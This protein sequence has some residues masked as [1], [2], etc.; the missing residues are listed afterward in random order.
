MSALP[1]AARPQADL[2]QHAQLI[3]HAIANVPPLTKKAVDP[4]SILRKLRMTENARNAA[5]SHIKTIG[6]DSMRFTNSIED[7]VHAFQVFTDLALHL[8]PEIERDARSKLVIITSNSVP[9]KSKDKQINFTRTRTIFQCQCGIDNHDGRHASKTREMGWEDVGCGAWMRVT[10]THDKRDSDKS[11]HV[12]LT[13]DEIIGDFSHS[14]LCPDTIKMSRDPRIPLHPD[15]RDYALSL[16]R[17]NIPLPQLRQHCR[18]WAHKHWGMNVGDK[19]YRYVFCDHETT[20]LYRTLAREAG[21]PQRSAAQDNLHLW[22]NSEDPHPPDPRLSA[23]RV[24]YSPFIP[25]QTERFSII[26]MTPEQKLLAWKFGHRKQLLMD[27]T[28]GV[29]NGRALLGILMALDDEMKGL[30][31]A[32]FLFTAKQ[33]TKAVHAD[34]NKALLEEQ[35]QLWK[36]G[37]GKND[38]G[39]EFEAYVAGTDNDPRERHALRAAWSQ[40]LLLLCIFHIWQ[41]WRNALNKFLRIIPEVSDRQQTRQHL[42]KFLMRLLKEIRDYDQAI[43]EYNAQ[44]HH[45]KKLSKSGGHLAKAQ[46][47]GALAFLTYLQGYL[48]LRDMWQSWSLAG[49]EE[50]ARR[51]GIPV[52]EVA[53]TTNHLESF[54]GRLKGVYFSPYM[55]SGRLPR[56]DFWVLTVITKVI[57]DFLESWAEK[58]ERKE[59]YNNMRAAAP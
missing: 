57:P 9:L 59:Y 4:E 7:Q 26:L 47:K 30:P 3:Q 37:M 58:R 46:A 28:F 19:T 25:G 27:L 53:R 14:A 6:V 22:F 1:Q 2:P 36:S 17:K 45:F 55:H 40:I 35:I 48:K 44:I 10:S 23:A 21:I 15:L 5:L 43:T 54:N 52:S 38:A 24:A 39:E 12:L 51:M 29:C 18:E 56:I 13:I 41:A 34:Y 33:D 8:P 42:A 20:S 16:L 49:A 31:V 50:A 11:N 32:F